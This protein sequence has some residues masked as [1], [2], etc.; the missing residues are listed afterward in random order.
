MCRI[1]WKQTLKLNFKKTGRHGKPPVLARTA[2][3]PPPEAPSG[4]DLRPDRR[5][6]NNLD[7]RYAALKNAKMTK[8]QDVDM[9]DSEAP[10]RAHS[11]KGGGKRR[12]QTDKTPSTQY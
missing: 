8:N 3:P 2:A 9:E 10:F 1:T 6:Q 5:S 7:A 4:P 12:W 11:A